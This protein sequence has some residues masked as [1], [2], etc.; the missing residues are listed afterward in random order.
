MKY[1]NIEIIAE[2]ANAHQGDP[3]LALNIAEEAIKA[4]ADAIKFQMYTP[5]E[6][7]SKNHKMYNIFKNLSFNKIEWEFIFN[8]ILKQKK[9]KVYLDI[10]GIESLNF[11]KK[12]KIDGY[13]VHFSDLMNTPLLVKL[14]KMNKLIFFGTG[15]ANIFEIDKAIKTIKKY[16]KNKSKL[17]LMHGFQGYPTSINDTNLSR[18]NFFSKNFSKFV[19]LGI[20]DHIEG[21]SYLS[22]IIPSLAIPMGIKYI[23]KHITINR[24]LKGYD[25]F[26]SLEAKEFRKFVKYIRESCSAMGSEYIKFSDSETKY[27]NSVKKKWSAL[28]YIEK[29]K[30]IKEED[31]TLKRDNTNIKTLDYEDIIDKKSKVTIKKD[32]LI[33]RKHFNHKI[34]ALVIARS[35]SSRLP[36]KATIKINDESCIS[37]LFNRL[38]INKS[39]YDK[40]VFCTT[41][42]KED[43]KL[44]KIA[45]KFKIKTYR[46]ESENVLKRIMLAINDNSDYDI[47]LRIQGD[48]ILIDINYIKKA[49]DFHLK[50]N[51][52]YTIP[53][54][55]PAGIEVEVIN[56]NVLKTILKYAQDLKGTEY[57]TN[58]IIENK[59]IFNIGKLPIP[60]KHKNNFR[61]TL[62]TLNDYKVINNLCIWL[63]ENNKKY[64]YDL[65]DINSFF[66]NNPSFKEINKDS[67]QKK[68]PKKFSTKLLLN[69]NC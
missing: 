54:G 20:S 8:N 65:D 58:Y 47:I 23:E 32:E 61:L 11:S 12:F 7:I 15:G 43:D 51:F 29:G 49:I 36:N 35:S 50:N 33:S 4:K 55:L 24:G 66:K 64:V 25:Y 18:L 21:N 56:K 69:K 60:K 52:D 39:F 14:S 3:K 16:N 2:I 46:G 6:L 45:K 13:K 62:D 9:I 48:D 28:R 10:F 17:V 41:K 44:V 68:I 57:L 31:I 1:N 37:Y 42:L 34:L 5:D 38:V 59:D 67:I 53:D 27:R 40:I 19:D 63:S 30:K 26:S 22:S